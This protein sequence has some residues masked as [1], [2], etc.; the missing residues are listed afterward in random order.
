M[1]RGYYETGDLQMKTTPFASVQDAP[2]LNSS[3]GDGEDP[4]A[5]R[6]VILVPDIWE[7]APLASRIHE[8]AEGRRQDVLLLG[9]VSDLQP[10]AVMRR[11]L[12]L[13]SAFLQDAGTKVQVRV[14]D[15]QLWIRD[16]ESILGDA[17]LLACCESDRGPGISGQWAE[18]LGN[19]FHRPIYVFADQ[20]M[21]QAPRRSVLYSVAP[22]VG[23]V[24]IIL[25]FLWLQISL[26]RASGSGSASA[27]LYG[28]VPAEF[29]LIWLLNALIV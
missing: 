12:T 28:S 2:L 18:T 23:S 15:S 22:W 3:V 11:K 14:K 9:M 1:R 29:G 25:G 13:L 4:G 10:E 21:P 5:G 20:G 26:N 6:L 27:L 7:A 19:R 17:D 8:V 16:L 24:V